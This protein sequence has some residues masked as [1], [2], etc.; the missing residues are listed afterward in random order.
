LR[1]VFAAV[2]RR[3]VLVLRSEQL[4]RD[5][6]GTL[7]RVFEF[8]GVDPGVR[9]E[10]ATV[11]ARAY[12]APLPADVKRDLTARFAAD[13]ADLETLLG[14]DLSDWRGA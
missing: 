2:P 12:E 14:W 9:V 5:H 11:H 7:R 3:Q 10:P 1:R 4:R 13:L 6:H 8:L